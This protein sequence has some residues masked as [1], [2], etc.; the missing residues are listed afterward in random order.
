MHGIPFLPR[1]PI[2]DMGPPSS[3]PL[4]ALSAPIPARNRTQSWAFLSL[5]AR[6]V[7]F[8][9][10]LSR[11]ARPPAPVVGKAINISISARPPL[12]PLGRE[13][14]GIDAANG[15]Q[16]STILFHFIT[17]PSYDFLKCLMSLNDA[18]A[19]NIGLPS[20]LA[21][22]P[23]WRTWGDHVSSLLCMDDRQ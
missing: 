14:E 17:S 5:P 1:L 7:A 8:V 22:P 4:L 11:S 10:S 18:F 20:D 16:L 3:L 2:R 6:P 23:H 12:V 21:I 19:S 15:S 13:I 9:R